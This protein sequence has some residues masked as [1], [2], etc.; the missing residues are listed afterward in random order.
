VY[1]DN[2]PLLE[3]GNKHAKLYKFG[4]D[5]VTEL[6]YNRENIFTFL[7]ILITVLLIGKIK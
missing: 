1:Q 5:I 6:Q 2:C 3:K 4:A 7:T